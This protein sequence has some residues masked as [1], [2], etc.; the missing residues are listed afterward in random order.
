MDHTAPLPASPTR[1]DSP[2]PNAPKPEAPKPEE[3]KPEVAKVEASAPSE[4]PPSPET[5]TSPTAPTKTTAPTHTR[6]K[7]VRDTNPFRVLLLVVVVF[8]S[9][10]LLMRT[11]AVEPFGVPTGSMAP[12]LIGHHRDG[13]C[14]RCGYPVRVGRPAGNNVNEYFS[15]VS[16]PNCDYHFSLASAP[17]INGDRLLVDKNIYSLRK[18]RRWEMVV[19]RCPDTDPKENG[20]PYVKRLI[21]LPGE[22]IRVIDGDVYLITPSGKEIVRKEL[23][24]VRETMIPV[25][26]MSFPPRPDGWRDRW[27]VGSETD[28]RLPH[29]LTGAK[30]PDPSIEGRALILDASDSPQTMTTVTYRH[31]DLDDRREEPI[32][33]WNSYDGSPRHFG[34]LP[35]AHDFI[36]TCELEVTA[37]AT[38]TGEASFACRLFDGADSVAGLITVGPKANGRAQIVWDHHDGLDAVSGVSLVPGKR[39]RLEFAFV[40]RRVHFALDGKL[41]V[42]AADLPLPE[43]RGEV[44][45][46]L[47]LGVR[48]CRIVLYDLK[49]FRDIHYTQ[50]GEHGTRRPVTMPEKQYYVLGDNSGNSQDSRKWPS[51]GVPEDDF[52]GKPF[53]IHQ[54]LKL[55]R[56]TVGGQE[57]VFQALDWSRL[58]W[59]H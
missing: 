37:A 17:D 28:P 25:F 52:I 5:S 35:A 26:D 13:P 8:S 10:F 27:L 39:Y 53:L 15:R 16:C 47:Y 38:T 1:P 46:P 14:P 6:P 34:Q 2:N 59:L 32:R 31:W 55:S 20:K 23:V 11:L 51:P 56:T 40:D 57:R 42:P 29:H 36:M 54:P 45:R 50:Y 49:L 7:P 19:F 48:G 24:E 43:S 4:T 33:V 18:P 58:R 44:R 41:V 30:T 12:S 21:G 9:L 3:L 22:T